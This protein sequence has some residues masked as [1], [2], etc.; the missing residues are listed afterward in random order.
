MATLFCIPLG[1]TTSAIYRCGSTYF[2]K[3]GFTKENHCLTVPSMV[4]PLSRTSRTTCL[5]LRQRRKTETRRGIWLYFCA[6]DRGPHLLRR[7][8]S[9]LASPGCVGHAEPG[10]LPG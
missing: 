9:Y 1:T 10:Y 4:L 3:A 7:R 6:I 5:V 2:R 8:S